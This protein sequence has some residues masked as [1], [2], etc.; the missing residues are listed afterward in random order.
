M[1]K[2]QIL[3]AACLV[4]AVALVACSNRKSAFR[5]VGETAPASILLLGQN[6]R[7]TEDRDLGK[8]A[9]GEKLGN[10]RRIISDDEWRQALIDPWSGERYAAPVDNPF[11]SV[12]TPGGDASTFGLDVDS[13]SYANVRRWLTDGRLPPAGAVRIEDFLNSF[14]YHYQPPEA[15]AICPLRPQVAIV[16]CPWQP[17]HRLVRIGIKGRTFDQQRRPPLNLVFLI[18]V[19]GSMNHSNKLPLVIDSLTKLTDSLDERD[20]LAIATYAG[21]SR[22]ALPAT[23]GNE[24]RAIKDALRTLSSDGST[25]GAGGIIAAYAEASKG[26]K[27]GVQSRIILCTDGDF[28]VGTTSLDALRTLITE[29]R[30]SGISLSVYGFG[31]GNTKDETMEMLANTGNGSYG[32]IDRAE[33]ADRLFVKGAMGQLV[34]IAKD[35]KIQIFF[36]PDAIAG[37]RLIGYEN[38]ILRREDF[39]NDRVDAGD[40]GSGHTVTALYEIVPKG[41]DV[42][43]VTGK[44]DANPFLSAG[45]PDAAHDA[46]NLLQLR[47]RWKNIGETQ[48]TLFEQHIPNTVIPM[49]SDIAHAAA[50]AAFGMLLRTSTA[51]GQTTWA[52]VESLAAQG[53]REDIQGQRREFLDLVTT[54]KGLAR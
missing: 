39:T 28:N 35:A 19:S 27:P 43:E 25:N 44:N 37:W 13:A 31:T 6:P 21:S 49:D 20:T 48:S 52:L 32:Y 45:K 23:P 12:A 38:R 18:D 15:S 14:D 8:G 42:P 9:E 29:K 7:P 47:I 30:T 53:L 24:K 5:T 22:M 2:I 51:K 54:A 4:C 41:V 46:V 34:T 16:T 17:Q 36:N 10:P 50:A 33:E 26:I 11:V 1:K 3:I 40:I